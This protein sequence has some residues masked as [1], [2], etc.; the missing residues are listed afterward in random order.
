MYKII[1]Q[2]LRFHVA[3]ITNHLKKISSYPLKAVNPNSWINMYGREVESENYS[4][5]IF[6]T[7]N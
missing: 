6:W 2:L 7:N 1:N 3:F 5:H 4:R